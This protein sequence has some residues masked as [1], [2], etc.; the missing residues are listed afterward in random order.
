MQNKNFLMW[1]MVALL[2]VMG[3]QQF[4][5]LPKQQQLAAQQKAEQEALKAQQPQTP[6]AVTEGSSSLV[7]SAKPNSLVQNQQTEEKYYAISVKNADITFSSKG[8]GIKE[9]I[10]KDVVGDVNLTPYK[11]EGFY[12]TMP[13]IQFD[14]VSKT[15]DT[16]SFRAFAGDITVNKTYTFNDNGINNVALS[17]TNRSK[18]AVSLLP[19]YYGF[20]PGLGTVE[21]EKN[22][23]E[24]EMKVTYT[25]KEE[26]K[27]H[28]ALKKVTKK[29]ASSVPA[30]GW[31]WAGLQ[32]RYFL[33]AIMP[34]GWSSSSFDTDTV[35]VDTKP[36]LWGLLGTANV[37]GPW[38]KINQ[39][40]VTL[41][42][43]ETKQ[44][45]SDFYIGPKDYKALQLLPYNLDRSVEFGFFGALGRI[46]RDIL[47]FL[48]KYTHN[49]GLAIIL[50]AVLLQL[51]MLK[52]TIM[53]QKSSLV[54]KQLQ[55]EMKRIQDKY[56]ND[57]Q[58]MQ[59][60][61]LAL[62]K[63]YKFNPMSG[64]LPLFLQLPI[65]IALFNAFRNS[66]ELHGAGFV[67]W[68]TDLSAKDPYYVLPVIMGGIML[69]QQRITAPAV[70]DP[71]Q[72]AMLKWMPV[73]FTFLF[74]NFPAGL[75]LYWLTNSIISFGVQLYMNKK[76]AKA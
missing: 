38:L 8:A 16:I 28:P 62:Y 68:I 76:M 65:F 22:D 17:F 35:V 48:Y 1:M 49:Y 10:F 29:N 14:F 36:R 47:E 72:A 25:I 44:F 60:E 46:A 66:W 55:P 42:A 3:Y 21:S 64:C 5:S 12:T 67:L 7:T 41:A 61:M 58:T 6:A 63:K 45:E 19:F 54:M 4:Y 57:Q 24:R 40:A 27:K 34:K 15:A 73:I 33:A 2:L 69:L 11:G 71:A 18:E 37:K 75:V 51:A 32:N 23:N 26:G 43:G 20:G 50:F 74:I 59:R 52:L 56:A 13:S 70:G 53:Q 30:S 31:I 39:P 9:Y